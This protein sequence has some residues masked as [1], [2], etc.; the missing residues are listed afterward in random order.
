M[1]D[2]LGPIPGRREAAPAQ[3]NGAVVP[4]RTS[5][6]IRSDSRLDVLHAVLSA[7]ETTRNGVAQSTGLSPATVVTIVSELLA[8]G[9][10]EERK[11]TAGRIG[12]PT[13]TLAMN[14]ARGFVVGMDIAETYISAVLFDAA[15]NEL[16]SVESARDEHVLDP[17]LRRRGHRRDARPAARRGECVS[18]GRARRRHRA[19]GSH[20]GSAGSLGGRARTGPGRPSNWSTCAHV[21]AC[22]S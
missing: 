2:S 21:S 4:R 16:R 10:I 17:G 1:T 8:E 5:R 19:S 18:R 6:D 13:A 14:K 7:G 12:R 15:L 22:L 9:I 11:V 3:G 20:P